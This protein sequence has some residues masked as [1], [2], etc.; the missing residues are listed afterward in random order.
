MGRRL[1]GLLGEDDFGRIRTSRKEWMT[2]Q[3]PQIRPLQK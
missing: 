2:G 3:P 1:G